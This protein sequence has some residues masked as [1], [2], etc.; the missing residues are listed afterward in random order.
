MFELSLDSC[1][2]LVVSLQSAV[3]RTVQVLTDDVVYKAPV[4]ASGS[5]Y[6]LRRYE[7]P[8]SRLLRANLVA[9]ILLYCTHCTPRVTGAHAESTR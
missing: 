9:I 2:S 3:N 1:A 6:Y 8:L 4:A 7:T 5:N